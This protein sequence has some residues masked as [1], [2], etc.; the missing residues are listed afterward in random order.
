[1]RLVWLPV[2]VACGG[3]NPEL[4][5]TKERAQLEKQWQGAWVLPYSSSA[6]GPYDVL[7]VTG[8]KLVQWRD[9]KPVEGKLEIVAPCLVRLRTGESFSYLPFAFE[10]DS[11]LVDKAIG[12]RSADEWIVCPGEGVVIVMSSNRC[13][14]FGT[15]MRKPETDS[16][17]NAKC[18]MEATGYKFTA[19]DI[20][21]TLAVAGDVLVPESRRRPAFRA[22]SIDDARARARDKN[23]EDS[24]DAPGLALVNRKGCLG[25]HS[26]DGSAKIGPSFKGLWGT[27]YQASNGQPVVVDEAYVRESV[28]DPN[29]RVRPSFPATCVPFSV[30]QLNDDELGHIVKYIES[31]R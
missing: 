12:V 21:T 16:G 18:D 1:M 17:I 27:S 31:L 15:K 8:T 2:V 30:S 29:A 24:G 22:A 5:T 25:C 6:G 4:L 23:L 14:A 28:R 7:E 19:A 26:I 13:R 20:T 3:S 9:D 11:L 10:R